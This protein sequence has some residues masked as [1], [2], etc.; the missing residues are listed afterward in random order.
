MAQPASYERRAPLSSS[1]LFS[2]PWR[3]L[4]ELS[5]FGLMRD[6]PD[7]SD[8]NALTTGVDTSG[9]EAKMREKLQILMDWHRWN[10]E[11]GESEAEPE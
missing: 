4:N 2:A 10:D 5:N 6:S 11:R 7:E 9:G 3:I 8:P 1:R